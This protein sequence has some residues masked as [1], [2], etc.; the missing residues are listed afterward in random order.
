MGANRVEHHGGRTMRAGF[1]K[2]VQPRHFL[3]ALFRDAAKKTATWKKIKTKNRKG[4][5]GN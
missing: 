2:N 4:F 5:S 1:A 3:F